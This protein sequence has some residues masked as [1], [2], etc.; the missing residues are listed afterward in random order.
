MT[1]ILTRK[2]RGSNMYHDS[3]PQ[4]H[5]FDAAVIRSEGVDSAGYRVER[6]IG[7]L[8]M[9]TRIFLV[10]ISKK[11]RKYVVEIKMWNLRRWAIDSSALQ[12]I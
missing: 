5:I 10:G 9:A 12:P 1:E 7:L 8:A 4:V 6:P 3:L 11:G 2:E